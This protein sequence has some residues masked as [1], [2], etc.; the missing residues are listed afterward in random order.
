MEEFLNKEPDKIIIYTCEGIE[1]T[2][3][4]RENE[5]DTFID[6]VGLKVNDKLLS[7]NSNW[8]IKY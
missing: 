7:D 6:I 2:I 5:R 4:I 3:H 1:F 8:V